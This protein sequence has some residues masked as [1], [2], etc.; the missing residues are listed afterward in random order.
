MRCAASTRLPACLR[1]F[2]AHGERWSQLISADEDLPVGADS[3]EG[4]GTPG[5]GVGRPVHLDRRPDPLQSGRS[6]RSIPGLVG[7]SAGEG[8]RGIRREMLIGRYIFRR[9]ARSVLRDGM[10]APASG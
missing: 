1:P 10:S 4:G 6:W 2:A 9:E 5:A 8:R 3:A 7:D